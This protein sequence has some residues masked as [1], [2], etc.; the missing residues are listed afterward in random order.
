[1]ELITDYFNELW[2][3]GNLPSSF[4]H[5]TVRFIPKPG[6]PLMLE[7]LRPIS[8]TSC[9]GKLLERIIQVCVQEYMEE[10]NL[11]THQMFGF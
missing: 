9:V 3:S 1:M 4:R 7:N 5:A 10:N 8:L 11:F 2:T 6:K